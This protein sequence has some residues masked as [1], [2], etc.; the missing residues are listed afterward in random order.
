[1]TAAAPQME[2]TK[3]RSLISQED[4]WNV[5]S[6]FSSWEEWEAELKFWGRENSDPHWPEI[7]SLR[8]G[9]SET[10]EH[11]KNLID[12]CLGID[13]GLSKLYTYAHL[14]HDEDV[15]EEVAKKAHSRVVA[16]LYAFRQET[17]WI[18]PELLQLPQEKIEAF[19][20]A[21]VLKDFAFY[22]E[23]IVRMKKHT[24]PAEQEELLALAGK[25]LQTSS[26]AFNALNNADM[27]FPPVENSQG[28]QMELTHG[29]YLL[30]M[31]SQDRKLREGAFKNVHREFLK[32]ENTVC[33]LL[34]GHVQCHLLQ[35]RARGY[36]SC[37]EAALYSNQI[38]FSVYSSLI[39]AVRK[40]LPSLH[41]YIDLRKKVLKVD[42]L[43]I[44]DLQ[45]PLVKDVE[46]GMPFEKAVEQIIESVAIL[47]ED[48]QRALNQG[49]TQERWVDRYENARKRSGAY[50]SGC[51]D[52]MPYI[53]M[54]YHGS[55]NDVLTLTH[56]AG[57]SMHSLLSHR[58]QPYQYS[59]YSIFV[60]EVASTFHEGLLLRHL[61][62][63]AKEKEVKAFLINQKLESIRSTLVRQ[64]MFAEFELKL[65]EWAQEGTPLTP[66]L[67]KQEYR[68]LNEEYF[69]P[70]LT[71]DE[72]I[73]IEWA[74]IPHFYSN[75][76]V[77]QYA[78]GISAAQALVDKVVNGGEADREKYLQFLSSG[79]SKYPIEVLRLAGVDMCTPEPVNSAMLH[80]DALVTELSTLL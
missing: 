74:R 75:F 34:N 55:L 46:M 66:A 62:K 1:M 4:K 39:T 9:W 22:I 63:G 23:Q 3:E 27:K 69:G 42:Q 51:Y 54:N 8:K 56:E 19:I 47:G 36:N 68:R 53:L 26:Q 49:L 30:Y 38:D 45:V 43:H 13:R 10:A 20:K 52:S 35:M 73:A 44:Y 50:S 28:V 41:R 76:Y 37:A 67:L 59:Q 14:R 79:S 33:E 21:P 70:G 15:S 12:V 31:R 29:K 64:T 18:E 6:L 58:H 16:L 48:Y 7:A 65:H 2:K 24:L 80:F 61:L 11:L 17:S 71:L 5:E 40:H 57:H 72:E 78:T 25:A 32:Y 60:A 77:Y